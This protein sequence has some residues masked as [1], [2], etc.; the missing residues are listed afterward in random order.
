DEYSVASYE[1]DNRERWSRRRGGAWVTTT[2]SS[3]GC[4]DHPQC[5]DAA[6]RFT[7]LPR[8]TYPTP[9]FPRRT[10]W[11]SAAPPR[12]DVGGGHD[13]AKM[14]RDH[15]ERRAVHLLI[16]APHEILQ[17]DDT[18]AEIAAFK[19]RIEHAA[20]GHGAVYHE[21]SGIEVAKQKIEIGRI[22]HGEALFRLH[23][24]V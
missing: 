15:L 8:S 6:G 10:R 12:Q 16:G 17:D 2:S 1:V 19:G 24:D 23:D 3:H 14:Q 4:G 20:I 13:D 9:L 18:I 7:P 11:L 5:A 21:Y 22:E